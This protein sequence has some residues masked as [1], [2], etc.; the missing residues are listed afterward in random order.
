M[1]AFKVELHTPLG[2]RFRA[3]ASSIQWRADSVSVHVA[4]RNESY[5]S[6]T[7]F[8]EITLQTREGREVFL[9][10]NAVSSLKSGCLM[11]LAE[12]VRRVN[13][14]SKAHSAEPVQGPSQTV[15]VRARIRRAL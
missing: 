9:L 1:K 11:V 6:S 5:L 2:C 13:G 7:H 15:P 8:T 10:K 14:T 4:R 12:N 3:M